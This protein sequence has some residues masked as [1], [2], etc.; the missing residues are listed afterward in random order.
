MNKVAVLAVAACIVAAGAAAQQAGQPY[1]ESIEVRVANIEVVVTDSE[2]R[3][4]RNLTKDDFELYEDGK[5]Q[6]VTNFFE[7]RNDTPLPPT[8]NAAAPG[9]PGTAGVP[10]SGTRPRH[11]VFFLDD[12]ATH[13]SKRKQLFDALESDSPTPRCAPATKR[14]SSPGIAR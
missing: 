14:W 6:T 2:N 13:P 8:A 9:D 5:L 10:D 3:H 12:Y 11:I 1:V 7:E 4:I